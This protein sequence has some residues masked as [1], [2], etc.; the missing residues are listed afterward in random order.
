MVNEVES[1]T[2][3]IR[4]A[5]RVD[6]R[7]VGSPVYKELPGLRPVD[8]TKVETARLN[9]FRGVL[10]EWRQRVD[11]ARRAGRPGDILTLASD[12]PTGYHR[13]ALLLESARGLID[14]RQYAAAEPVL[15]QVVGL[16]PTSADVD[17]QSLLGLVRNR[18][19]R[20]PRR[21]CR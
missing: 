21:R 11:V 17:A 13:A 20:S 18:L 2:V 8:W 4:E 6:D 19:G 10:N 3:R 12:A 1:L 16:A 7:S 15:D 9:F 5:I 14:L